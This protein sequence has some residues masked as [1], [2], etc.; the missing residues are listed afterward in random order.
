[1]KDASFYLAQKKN[2]WLEVFPGT[3]FGFTN[4][5]DKFYK[6]RIAALC[7]LEESRLLRESRF[8]NAITKPAIVAAAVVTYLS[9]E[10]RVGVRDKT[11][12]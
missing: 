6:N 11:G 7:S 9:A 10:A 8:K 4:I 2:L 5:A 12:R 1:M 3:F